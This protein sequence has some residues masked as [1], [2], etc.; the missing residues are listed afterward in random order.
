MYRGDAREGPERYRD[1]DR[2]RERENKKTKIVR[3]LY[4]DFIA[5]EERAEGTRFLLLLARGLNRAAD[6]C[7]SIRCISLIEFLER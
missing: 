1:R 3:K 6:T 5:S 7:A 4:F 2:E